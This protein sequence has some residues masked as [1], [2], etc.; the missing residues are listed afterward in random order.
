MYQRTNSPAET[1]EEILHALAI[2]HGGPKVIFFQRADAAPYPPPDT[3]G[4][5]IYLVDNP[6][7]WKDLM[8]RLDQEER[9]QRDLVIE[10]CP[11]VVHFGWLRHHSGNAVGFCLREHY[12]KVQI[13]WPTMLNGRAALVGA[14]L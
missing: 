13:D 9:F 12:G 14:P 8:R 4:H 3:E 2:D 7:W 6:A 10:D 1:L 5:V 11:K